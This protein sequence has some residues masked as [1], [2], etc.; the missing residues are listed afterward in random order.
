MCLTCGGKKKPRN[1]TK[2]LCFAYQSLLESI[3]NRDHEAIA[4]S[5]EKRLFNK[6][7]NSNL[8]DDVKEIEVLN[9][10]ENLEWTELKVVDC[11]NI[12]GPEID[13]DTNFS[14]GELRMIRRNDYQTFIFPK[15][16][17]YGDEYPVILQLDIQI[18]T[19]LKLNLIDSD[20]NHLIPYRARGEIETHYLRFE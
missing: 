14:K 7:M 17:Q 16:I 10:D 5:C 18:K 1:V 8:T 11:M 9:A 15:K 2:S 13:R 3:A 4:D 19:P 6:F 20:G 12:Y